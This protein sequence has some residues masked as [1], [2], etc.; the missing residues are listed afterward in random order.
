MRCYTMNG[1][2]QQKPAKA[3]A[4][5]SGRATGTSSSPRG[6]TPLHIT[7]TI[8]PGCLLHSTVA[9]AAH[10]SLATGQHV[11]AASSLPVTIQTVFD[12]VAAARSPQWTWTEFQTDGRARKY[13]PGWVSREVR[14][15]GSSAGRCAGA[16]APSSLARQAVRQSRAVWNP[17]TVLPPSYLAARLVHPV[18]AGHGLQ[19]RL[20]GLQRARQQHHTR[21]RL[22]RLQRLSRRREQ[23]R[24]G[25]RQRRRAPAA[26]HRAVRAAQL[27]QLLH[28]HGQGGG[29]LQWRLQ[30]Q[31]LRHQRP[32][33][34]QALRA[35]ARQDQG[36]PA[37]ASAACWRA[38]LTWPAATPQRAHC[39]CA[40]HLPCAAGQRLPQLP[41]AF[42]RAAGDRQRRAQIQVVGGGRGGGGL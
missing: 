7:G 8:G 17:S 28:A 29:Q 15:P 41:R 5:P 39:G 42:D 30:L 9:A 3:D 23:C 34:A 6:A 31:A 13:K 21:Q 36:A 27:P 12:A 11:A 40:A 22:N 16:R 37:P 1:Q 19:L 2:Q 20:R 25:G 32:H 4:A 14:A 24:R 10:A 18:R 26:G 35:H 33:R 38:L